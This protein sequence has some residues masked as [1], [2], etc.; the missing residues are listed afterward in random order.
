MIDPDGLANNEENMLLLIKEMNKTLE[1]KIRQYPD[2]WFW[3]H[4]RWKGARFF[5]E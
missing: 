1:D 5:A 4:K 2:Q 3:L